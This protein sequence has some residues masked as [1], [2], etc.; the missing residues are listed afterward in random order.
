MPGERKKFKIYDEKSKYQE[1]ITKNVT[2]IVKGMGKNI[3]AIFTSI[4]T[5]TIFDENKERVSA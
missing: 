5:F 1:R 2:N 4:F 3:K